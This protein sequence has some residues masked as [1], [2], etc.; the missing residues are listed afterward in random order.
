MSM[1]E[2][3]VSMDDRPLK[4]GTPSTPKSMSEAGVSFNNSWYTGICRRPVCLRIALGNE[5][6]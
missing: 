3:G 1:S 5:A 4:G 6:I 2:A